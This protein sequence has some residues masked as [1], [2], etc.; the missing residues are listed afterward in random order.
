[1]YLPTR[2]Q[3]TFSAL[4]LYRRVA[5]VFCLAVGIFSAWF[6]RAM[7][8][9]VP[10]RYQVFAQARNQEV[11]FRYRVFVQPEPETLLQDRDLSLYDFGG[12]VSDCRVSTSAEMRLCNEKRRK[13]RGF[14]LSHWKNKRRAYLIVAWTGVDC[15]GDYYLFI[16]PDGKGNWI[17]ERRQEIVMWFHGTNVDKRVATSV[18]SW[19]GRD[20]EP[21]SSR[22]H[23]RL[24]FL[25]DSGKI[26][27]EY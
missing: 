14:I 11:G 6:W 5:A 1:M 25:D 2:F 3:R 27:F 9:D 4:H 23:K 22:G 24:V 10:F 21:R 12:H 13:A 15:F 7:N 20:N 8:D 16:E 26:V 18:E 19:N 17:I